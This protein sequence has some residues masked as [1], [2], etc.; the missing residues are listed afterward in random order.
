MKLPKSAQ[1]HTATIKPYLGSSAYDP[2]YGDEFKSTG[3]YVQK[4]RLTKD[5]EGNEVLS[6]SQYYTSDDINL[7][8][9]SEITFK[10]N[11]E[12]VIKTNRYSN[13]LTGKLSNV[14]V[15]LE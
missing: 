9:Q 2:Q 8:Q 13:A 7:K 4:N 6:G 10:N 3:Y 14:E 15:M 5:D 1:P 11:T 12:T